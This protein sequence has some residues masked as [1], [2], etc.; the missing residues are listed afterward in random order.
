MVNLMEKVKELGYTVVHIKT[1]SIKIANADPYIVKVIMD[2]GHKYGYTFE[3]EAV[4]DRMAIVNKAVYISKIALGDDGMKQSKICD[5]SA[6]G[7]QFQ[8]PYV[9]KTL[10]SHEDYSFDDLVQHKSARTPVYICK[11]EKPIRFVGKEGNFVPVMDAI[12]G[13]DLMTL[14]DDKF[15]SISGTK[16]YRWQEAEVVKNNH[17]EDQV[18][19]TYFDSLADSAKKAI[20]EYIPGTRFTDS[21]DF[22][23]KPTEESR[24]EQMNKL[25]QFM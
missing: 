21:I 6:T 5:W 7:K 14:R 10:F 11:G 13:G 17:N 20:E 4:Y 23:S 2:Y 19:L 22:E 8:E 25:K 15:N 12:F 1:D 3:L 18:D 16:G 24:L 9:F